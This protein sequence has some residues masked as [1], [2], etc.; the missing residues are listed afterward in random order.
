[1][2]EI[3]FTGKELQAIL[4]CVFFSTC[5]DS[6]WDNAH[7]N[8][9]LKLHTQIMKKFADEGWTTDPDVYICGPGPFEDNLL[10]DFVTKKTNLTTIRN[11]RRHSEDKQ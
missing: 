5:P 7:S 10:V 3:K 4:N 8:K 6:V 1:M 11:I 9:T 2:S